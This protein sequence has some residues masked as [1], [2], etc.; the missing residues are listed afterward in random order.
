MT[1]GSSNGLNANKLKKCGKPCT[2]LACAHE[3][4]GTPT[5]SQP[6]STFSRN[7]EPVVPKG[8]YDRLLQIGNDP[9]FLIR[10][11]DA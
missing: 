6:T 1:T 10:N 11:F 4:T 5:L 3:S 8:Q 2:I 7:K 9:L